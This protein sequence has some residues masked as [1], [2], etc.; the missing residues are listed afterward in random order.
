VTTTSSA[1]S[2]TGSSYSV[3]IGEIVGGAV[4]GTLGIAAIAALAW[5]KV[6]KLKVD[7]EASGITVEVPISPEV[8]KGLG[9]QDFRSQ[10]FEQRGYDVKTPG[11]PGV[12]YP[13]E[14]MFANLAGRR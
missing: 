3:P 7:K 2:P 12:V 14:I 4:G 13:D 5:Y 11:S 9:G 6:S 1:S 8:E 10:G